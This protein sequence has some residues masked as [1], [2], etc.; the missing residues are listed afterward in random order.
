MAKKENQFV[1][2][3][4]SPAPVSKNDVLTAGAKDI[5]ATL[6]KYVLLLGIVSF[7]AYANTLQNG[8]ALDDLAVIEQNA[9]VRQG[10]TAVPEILSTPFHYGNFRATENGP[11][12]DDLYRPLSLATFAIEYQVW[13]E[14]PAPAHFVNIMLYVGCVI[15]FFLF[16]YHIFPKK[17]L[18]AFIA[19][20]L[21]AIHPIHTEVAANIKSRDELLCFLFGFLSLNAY[22]R[23][24]DSNRLRHLIAGVAF[25]FLSLLSKETSVTFLAIIP[26]IFFLYRNENKKRSWQITLLSGAIAVL[27]LVIRFSVLVSHRAYNPSQVPF[28]ENDLIG[29][30]SVLSRLATAILILGYYIKL[31][32]IPYPLV[33]DYSF[34]AIPFV[35]FTN[36]QVWLSLLVYL[37]I[38]G[39]AIFRLIKQRKDPLAFGLLFFLVTL[40]IFSN[41]FFLIGSEMSERFLFFP[42]AGFCLVAAFVIQRVLANQESAGISAVTNKKILIILVPLGIIFISITVT[43]NNDWKDSLTLFRTDLEKSPNNARLCYFAATQEI[44]V[45][46]S[47]TADRA[48]K[49]DMLKE[50]I[51]N[52]QR[53][54]SIYPDYGQ[55][56]SALTDA[57]LLTMQTDSAE[58]HGKKAVMLN[59]NDA[60]S[61]NILSD[62]FISEKKYS[63]AEI[64]LKKATAINPTNPFYPGNLAIC[65]VYLKQ[66]DSAI[67]YFKRSLSIEP[68]NEK[69]TQFLAV[70]YNATGQKDSARKYESI[71]KR[72]SPGFSV[73]SITLPN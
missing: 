41:L 54:V 63:E 32:I 3:K 55:A 23:Y 37:F 50:G 71:A 67:Y 43:R 57:F 9:F 13:G 21:F 73:N 26:L 34:N 2:K 52:L 72:S 58:L 17:P 10:I 30:P 44:A 16:L 69:A 68:D 35:N 53:S 12:I 4:T 8:Y 20:F 28:M 18:I 19:A 56:H 39:Y 11:A 25:Y 62:V 6:W 64:Q 1:I 70:T 24:L 36:I 42:S 46:K 38:A 47:D 65:C 60:N 5:G 29:A 61:L 59:G 33:C 48:T 49:Q 66:Y 45:T 7:F 51:Q 14:N 31:L 15:V 22:I 40:S 27:Y